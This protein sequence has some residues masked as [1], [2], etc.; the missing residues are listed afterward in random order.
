MSI[1]TKTDLENLLQEKNLGNTF[2]SD[3]YDKDPFDVSLASTEI[4][5][6][7]TELGGGLPRGH[8]SEI[9]GAHSTGRM[10]VMHAVF[11]AATNRGEFVALIDTFDT[12][13]PESGAEAGIDFSRFLWIR[14]GA[15]SNEPMSHIVSRSL[16]ALE[17]LV[18]AGGFGVVA[19]DLV[20]LP[21]RVFRRIP[22]TT[23]KRLTHAVKDQPTAYLLIGD[24]SIAR[25][26]AGVTLRLESRKKATRWSCKSTHSALLHGFDIVVRV[27][28]TRFPQE[29]RHCQLFASMPA[30]SHISNF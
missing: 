18:H 16:K 2:F 12:F 28:G 27:I 14:G 15:D 11:A 20:D 29:G 24:R 1:L 13:D 26:V 3:T 30:Y 21:E 7:D 5:R 17:C 22:F 8:L 10:S 25:S 6:L 23:W 9:V 4:A 19:F